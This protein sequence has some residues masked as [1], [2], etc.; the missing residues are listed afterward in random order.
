MTQHER[1]H[2]RLLR[3]FLVP[4][5]ALLGVAACDASAPSEP[6]RTPTAAFEVSCTDL[7]CDFDARGSSDP[8]GSIA[9]F[10]WTLGDGSSGSGATLSHTYGS[11]GTWSVSLTVTDDDGA[12][13]NTTRQVEVAAAN[14]PP[15]ASFVATCDNLACSF[16]AAASG[17]SDGTIASYAWDFGDANVGTGETVNHTYAAAGDYVVTLTVTD[18]RGGAGSASDTLSVT[19]PGLIQVGAPIEGS[20]PELRDGRVVAISDDGTRVVTGTIQGGAGSFGQVRVFEWDGA[21]WTQLGQTL[22]NPDPQA[23]WGEVEAV[24]LSGDGRRVA[25]GNQLVVNPDR[26]RGAVWVYELAGS[27][28][29]QM[30]AP[31]SAEASPLNGVGVS[32]AFNTD[33]SRLAVG[34]L[35]SASGG[36][37]TPGAVGVFEWDGGA[38]VPAGA[39]V[40]GSAERERLGTSVAIS[41]DGTRLVA[42]APD[43]QEGGVTAGRARVYDWNGSGWTEV[44]TPPVGRLDGPS[45]IRLGQSVTIS[46]DGSRIAAFG[47]FSG[48]RVRVFELVGGDWVQ[49][50]DPFEVSVAFE[51]HKPMSLSADGSRIAVGAPFVEVGRGRVGVY[52]WNG[53]SWELRTPQ[54]E[55]EV[56]SDWL[57]WSVA[58]TPDGS[59]LVAGMPG[60]N[61]GNTEPDNR[62][63]ARVYDIR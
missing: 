60:W 20:T 54:V 62:G 2:S 52:D 61:G 18:D 12:S 11:A 10:A 6:N 35:L 3:A 8:D 49:M 59:R 63:G 46:Q 15:T 41:G 28:W 57:G 43:F 19:E 16:D 9:T 30:G 55:G 51:R 29:V 4:S 21:Q 56:V 26:S 45:D 24:T 39:P 7:T 25:V 53:T 58:M 50:G 13:S 34:A 48:D 42:G 40:F 44:G 31:I 22:L 47:N 23:S 36:L 14:L 1:R 37:D 32:V 27:S 33:G 17:D 5:L 38:W